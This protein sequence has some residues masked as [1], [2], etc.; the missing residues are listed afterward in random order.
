MGSWASNNKWSLMG[1]LRITAQMISYEVA[2]GLV[3]C[4]VFMISGENTARYKKGFKPQNL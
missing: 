3:L 1:G 4:G 2:I